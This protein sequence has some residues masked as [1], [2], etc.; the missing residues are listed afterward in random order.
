VSEAV[1]VYTFV[2]HE[3]NSSAEISDRD[4]DRVLDFFKDR[5]LEIHF[6]SPDEWTPPEIGSIEPD[7]EQRIIDV[8]LRIKAYIT[9][10]D[11]HPDFKE[12]T[13]NIF[14]LALKRGSLI[15]DQANGKAYVAF[16]M[17]KK[18]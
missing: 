6:I 9:T 2:M 8:F 15:K 4:R 16:P 13:D 7:V 18:D 5:D 11:L 1:V 12:I 3:Q 17:K 10:H 14:L